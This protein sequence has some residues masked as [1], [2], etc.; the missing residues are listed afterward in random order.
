MSTGAILL[1]FAGVC[2]G[3]SAIIAVLFRFWPRYGSVTA[4]LDSSDRY[5]AQMDERPDQHH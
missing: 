2:I 3:V 4:A 5:V 1:T